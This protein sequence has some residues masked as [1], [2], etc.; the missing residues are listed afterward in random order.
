MPEP[1]VTHVDNTNSAS[2][3]MVDSSLKEFLSKSNKKQQQQQY[4]QQVQMCHQNVERDYMND[5]DQMECDKY[6]ADSYENNL[7]LFDN[8]GHGKK[9][10]G[11]IGLSQKK[12]AT[13]KRLKQKQK[14]PMLV[15]TGHFNRKSNHA[16][17]MM[18][19]GKY[20][21]KS[22]EDDEDEDEEEVE[23]N[24]NHDSS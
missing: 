14:K 18:T 12:K 15:N 10:P 20:A 11:A 23:N 3:S 2:V 19:H 22:D 5:D 21:K 9:L 16:N 8:S 17:A 6:A 7:R 1:D 13:S 4:Q 24:Y